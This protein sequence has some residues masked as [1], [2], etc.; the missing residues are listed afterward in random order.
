MIRAIEDGA[1]S[2]ALKARLAE[3]ERRKEHLMEDLAAADRAEGP[4]IRIHPGL[5]DRY[6][7]Q[8]GRLEE[9]LLDASIRGEAEEALRSLIERVVLR[10]GSDGRRRSVGGDPRGSGGDPAARR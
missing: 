2:E 9:A 7:D 1:W 10:A 6:R 3:L 5:I 4:E 8:V